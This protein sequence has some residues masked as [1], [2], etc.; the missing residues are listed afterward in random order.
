MKARLFRYLDSLSARLMGLL[1]GLARKSNSLAILLGLVFFFS[2]QL[3]ALAGNGTGQA[4]TGS[5][6]FLKYCAGCHGFDGFA[7]YE[8]APSFSMGDRLYRSDEELLRSVIAGRHAMPYWKH[9]LSIDMLR[10]AIAYLRVM[11]QRHSS[12]LPPREEPIPETYYRFNPVGE[13]E[14]YWLNR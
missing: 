8:F 10:S 12:G 11:Q 4:L 3:S 14:D 7:E 5:D 1:G 13:D 9:K 6:I 2:Y